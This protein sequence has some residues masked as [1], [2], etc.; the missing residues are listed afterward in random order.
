VPSTPLQYGQRYTAQVTATGPEGRTGTATTSFFTMAQ[1]TT[2][3]ISASVNVMGGQ[4]YGVGMPI[5]V[6]FGTAIPAAQRAA[7]QRRLFVDSRPSQVGAWRWFSSNEIMYRPES[8]WKP[9]T[10]VSFRAGLAGVPIGD[11]VIGKDRT[12][13]FTIGRDMEISVTNADHQLTIKS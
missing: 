10:Q 13:A 12:A 4:T 7:V 5:V 2:K 11:R 9:G 3:P 6:D 8:Y 1:P